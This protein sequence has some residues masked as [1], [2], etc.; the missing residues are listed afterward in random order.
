MSEE[1]AARHGC[2]VGVR[3]GSM[4]GERRVNRISVDVSRGEIIRIFGIE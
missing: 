3:G 1:M 2:V 4:S